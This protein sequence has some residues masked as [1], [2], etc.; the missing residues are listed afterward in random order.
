MKIVRAGE[1]RRFENA[2]S[3]TAFEYDTGDAAINV[4]RI[5][6]SG[7]YP[8]E[9]SAMNADVTELVYVERGEG[10]VSV[11]GTEHA[12]RAG[13]VISIQKGERAHWDGS[14]TLVIACTP[15]W[16]PEQYRAV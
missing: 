6:I 10:T 2:A 15:A 5:E 16:T 7:R 12:L 4:A 1:A 13:D 9:G 11:E 8:A 3:C 14:L